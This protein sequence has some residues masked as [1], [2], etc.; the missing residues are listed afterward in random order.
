MAS[1]LLLLK[2]NPLPCEFIDGFWVYSAVDECRHGA[3]LAAV[4]HECGV[5]IDVNPREVRVS[6]MDDC[7]YAS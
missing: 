3:E 7:T 6:C 1:P 5:F 2:D 4:V